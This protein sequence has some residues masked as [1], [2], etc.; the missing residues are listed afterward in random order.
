MTVSL[1]VQHQHNVEC[2]N[3]RL[4]FDF[5]L[6]I[7]LV[8]AAHGRDVVI[9]AG[10]GISTEVPPAYPITVMARAAERLGRD[11]LETFPATMQAFQDTFGRTEMVQMIKS[12]FN[13]IDSFRSLRW[14]A[15]KFHREL[16]TMPYLEDIVTTNWDTYFEEEC[17]AT[18]F[19][20]GEDIALWTMAGRKVLKIHGS[21]TNLASIV[22]TEDDY[23]RRLEDM[24]T[25]LMGSFLRNFLATRTVVF[26]GYSLTDWNFRWL[27]ETLMKDMKDY[28]PSAYF[29]SPSG[30]NSED[31]KK[32]KLKTIKTSGV[33]FLQ[34]LKQ[35][36]LGKCFIKD[37]N[38]ARVFKYSM[39]I[40]EA[41]TVGKTISHKEYPAV[42]YSWAF[43]DG[44]KDSCYRIMVRRPSGEYSSRQYV[45][46][47]IK[48]Y[49][50]LA[51]TAWD[52]ERYW[53]HAYIL[54]YLT[55]MWVMLDDYEDLW[56]QGVEILQSASRYLVYG[57][58]E[59]SQLKTPD[60]FRAALELSRRRAPKQR[61][62][63]RL[64]ADALPEGMVITHEPFLPGLP[65]ENEPLEDEHEYD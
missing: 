45:K 36:N 31:E 60:D 8:R 37:S 21:I 58:E 13:Y 3:C 26:V 46:D 17:D 23:A 53:D 47:R 48:V 24:N 39:D 44:A 62:A 34:D 20:S 28:A 50:G 43:H 55:P 1:N 52:E 64:V 29:V 27:Y 51:D 16:A 40:D 18:P 65:A 15:R 6:P 57:V 49:E 19:I 12:K 35:A 10:A 30:I 54:G 25:N 2:A 9:F 7:E 38:Y 14:H 33:K 5:D 41:E 59:K 42:I 11:D 56:E 22:A 61:K 4:D 63:A 32:F